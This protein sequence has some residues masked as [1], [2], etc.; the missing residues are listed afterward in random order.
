MLP[1]LVAFL[2]FAP[3]QHYDLGGPCANVQGPGSFAEILAAKKSGDWNRIIESQK[4]FVRERCDIQYRWE[5]LA[6]TLLDAHREPDAVKVLEEMDARGFEV[7]PALIDQT[8]PQLSKFMATASFRASPTGKKVE[9]LKASSEKR[10]AHARELLTALGQR[11]PENNVAKNTCPFECCTYREWTVEKDTDL[12]A[13]PGSTEV[14]G[15]ARKGTRVKGLTGDV[16]LTPEPVY[17]VSATGG[18]PKDTVAFILDREGEG[19]GHVW[20]RGK[21]VSVFVGVAKYCFRP[22]E[23][24]WAEEIEPDVA[25]KKPV[26]WVKVR[27]AN[28]VVGWTDHTAP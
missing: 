2:M 10:R 19:Y 26:W 21:V 25:R 23:S 4:T 15:K 1:L 18:I 11:P 5:E 7:N 24:C 6:Q 8:H 28:G 14:V 22:S 3:D 16:H 20:T 12:V 13:A 27:L 17:V 9:A